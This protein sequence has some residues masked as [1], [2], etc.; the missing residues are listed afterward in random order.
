MCCCVVLA[1][2]PNQVVEI[3]PVAKTF[4]NVRLCC[5]SLSHPFVTRT[6]CLTTAGLA[7]SSASTLSTH[8][9]VSLLACLAHVCGLLMHCVFADSGGTLIFV[10]DNSNTLNGIVV[11]HVCALHSANRSVHAHTGQTQTKL[12]RTRCALPA[13][14]PDRH[15]S[16]HAQILMKSNERKLVLALCTHRYIWN[17]Y[18][19]V[20]FVENLRFSALNFSNRDFLKGKAEDIF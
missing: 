11:S 10:N 16:C 3:D 17:A 19:F 8:L 6:W 9:R 2:T 14:D 1:V 7:P 13:R 15:H 18:L 5:I 20:E 4:V 12:G